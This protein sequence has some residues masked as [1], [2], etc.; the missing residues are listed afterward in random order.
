MKPT[1]SITT[2]WLLARTVALRASH[3]GVSRFG[4]RPRRSR[5]KSRHMSRT[6]SAAERHFGGVG[7]RTHGNHPPRDA[8]AMLVGAVPLPHPVASSPRA[9]GTNPRTLSSRKV[10][11][12]ARAWR[13]SDEGG[14]PPVA[15]SEDDG[16]LHFV[17][18]PW[19]RGTTSSQADERPATG[20]LNRIP[21]FARDLVVQAVIPKP[22]Q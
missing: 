10:R 14:I 7:T 9:S 15:P 8:D 4:Q 3:S 11:R 2:G 18:T 6:T 20:D 17:A 5:R 21:S 13:P 19:N 22:Q 12:S 16:Q 1:K